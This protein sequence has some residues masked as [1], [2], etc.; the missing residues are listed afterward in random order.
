MLKPFPWTCLDRVGVKIK[1]TKDLAATRITRV[2]LHGDYQGG[3]MK[4]EGLHHERER[5]DEMVREK[6]EKF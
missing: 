4:M 3:W 2:P 5:G 1:D 6:E